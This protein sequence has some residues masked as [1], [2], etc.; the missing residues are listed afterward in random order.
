M[1]KP[2]TVKW[3]FGILIFRSAFFVLAIAISAFVLYFKP[4]QGFLTGFVNR[5]IVNLGINSNAGPNY[6]MGSLLFFYGIR[7]AI[8]LLEF[9]FFRTRMRVG[10][11]ILIAFDILVKLANFGFPLLSI[12][13]LILAL[14][15]PS[16]QYLSGKLLETRQS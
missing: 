13:T 6:I 12:I 7:T 14:K 2:K 5:S 11:W 3:I 4:D 1:N 15:E 9:V 10:F 16:K 8:V